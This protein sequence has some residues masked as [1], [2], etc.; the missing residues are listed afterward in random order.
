VDLKNVQPSLQFMKLDLTSL[1]S[2]QSFAREFSQICLPGA[3]HLLV[4]NA[5]VMNHPIELTRD[6]IEVTFSTNYLGHFYLTKLLS[7]LFNPKARILNVTSG[8]YE[9][10]CPCQR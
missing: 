10:L 5:G 7:E 1:K 4:N 8:Y 3:L 6:G 2:V 9:K